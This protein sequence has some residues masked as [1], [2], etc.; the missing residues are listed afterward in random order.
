[1]RVPPRKRLRREWTKQGSGEGGPLLAFTL[2]RGFGTLTP[3]I[4]AKKKRPG[5]SDGVYT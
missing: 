2:A 3:T 1:M 5:T 4:E